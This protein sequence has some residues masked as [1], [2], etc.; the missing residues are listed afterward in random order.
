MPPYSSEPRD[1]AVSAHSALERRH[2]ADQRCRM[3][4]TT[5]SLT[6]LSSPRMTAWCK[7]VLAM[8]MA[9]HPRVGSAQ[10]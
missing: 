2:S 7:V 3:R 8:P 5:R 10:R 6:M 4:S 9:L 1:T